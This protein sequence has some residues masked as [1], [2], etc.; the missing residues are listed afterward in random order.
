ML[1]NFNAYT[2][3]QSG[4]GK[5]REVTPTWYYERLVWSHG[6]YISHYWRNLDSDIHT[7]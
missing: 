3:R 6:V 2:Y 4:V 1:I 7:Q 5:Q